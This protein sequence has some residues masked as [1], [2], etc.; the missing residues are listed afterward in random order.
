MGD[1]VPEDNKE[2][3]CFLLLQ[4]ITEFATAP[5]VSEDLP[6]YMQ[7]DSTSVNF[8]VHSYV[9]VQVLIEMHH[10]AFTECYPGTSL[11]PKCTI[12]FI[13]HHNNSVRLQTV[14]IIVYP[15]FTE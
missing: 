9:S 6:A 2:W 13:Y 1:D 7:V 5:I 12:C 14:H 3:K 8:C 10:S 11:I 4:E 15:F